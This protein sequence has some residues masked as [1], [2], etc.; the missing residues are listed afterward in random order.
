MISLLRPI[1][2]INRGYYCSERWYH[3]IFFQNFEN[4]LIARMYR[5]EVPHCRPYYQLLACSS[6]R[7]W[8][9]TR[10]KKRS[11]L[12]DDLFVKRTKRSSITTHLLYSI[13][14]FSTP[15]KVGSVIPHRY[16]STSLSYHADGNHLFVA[17]EKDSRVTLVD[18]T[19]IGKPIGHYKCDREGVSCL[20][21]T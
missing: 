5:K 7:E 14:D 6:L 19:R 18:A 8:V 2:M 15:P 9:S 1:D 3:E 17:N 20:S 21:A 12:K 4:F 10:H 16:P 13:M 11:P